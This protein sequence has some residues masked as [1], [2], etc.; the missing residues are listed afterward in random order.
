MIQDGGPTLLLGA[1][2]IPSFPFSITG[3]AARVNLWRFVWTT[4]VGY[5]PLTI[6][7][8]YLGSQAQSLSVGNPAIWATVLLLVGLLITAHLVMRGRAHR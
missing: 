6:A 8:A 5:L 1:R 2:L 7:V 4:V 3:Y